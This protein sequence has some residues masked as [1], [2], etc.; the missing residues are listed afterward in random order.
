MNRLHDLIVKHRLHRWKL[1]RT[2][3][4]IPI[5]WWPR[6]SRRVT[7]HE[8]LGLLNGAK[9]WPES[10]RYRLHDVEN[11]MSFEG[12]TAKDLAEGITHDGVAVKIRYEINQDGDE[13][14]VAFV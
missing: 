6:W 1:S 13:V 8:L 12:Y 2:G 7:A 4:R 5:M 11:V 3:Y 9:D 14:P 10:I